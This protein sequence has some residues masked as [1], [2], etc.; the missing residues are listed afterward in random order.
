M[1][2]KFFYLIIFLM[3]LGISTDF[4]AQNQQI[5]V[6]RKVNPD[7][8]VSL[9]YEKKMPG[10]YYLI[11]EFSN[12]TNCQESDFKCVVSGVNG[13]V[14]KIRPI[15]PQ[16]HI[17]FSYRY[18]S[19][20]G[21]LNPKVDSLFHYTL[22]FKNGKKV[23]IYEAGNIGEKY[24]ESDKPVNWKSYVV[25]STSSDTIYSMRKGIVVKLV[26]DYN[27]EDDSV[28]KHYTSERNLILIEHEDGTLAGYKGF[29]KDSFKVKLG[30]TVYPQTQL[31]VL[32]LFNKN[33]NSYRLDFSIRY[34]FDGKS[35][36][37]EK[38]TFKNRK[39]RYKY[40]TPLFFTQ[41][42]LLAITS[43]EEYTTLFN[44][45]LLLKEFTRSEKK[46]YN[47]DLTSSK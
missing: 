35:N 41:E 16:Q 26:N 4:F 22:P 45:E 5:T 40:I 6:T 39:S 43:K 42:G 17:N 10:S 36:S 33:E 7:K 15:N 34:L 27:N 14:T 11:I 46:K 44:E 21:H 9:Y 30:Q 23:K 28:N 47:K 3:L 37:D 20:L 19:I 8:S 32:E 1:K 24:F 38:Q 13:I 12:Q 18:S 29:K 25:K 31:G 2:N